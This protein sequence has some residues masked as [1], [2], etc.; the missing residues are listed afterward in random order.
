MHSVLSETTIP[1]FMEG[2]QVHIA[3]HKLELYVNLSYSALQ[4]D[5][6]R[7]MSQAEDVSL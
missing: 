1:L 3:C 5:W 2:P 7:S 4:V 6:Q